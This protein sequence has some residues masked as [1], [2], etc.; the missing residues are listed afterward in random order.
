MIS[1]ILI[2]VFWITLFQSSVFAQTRILFVGNSYTAANNLP[3]LVSDLSA[4]IGDTIVFASNSPGGYTFQLHSSDANTLS[5]IQSQPWDFVVLQEQSQRPAFPP[6]QVAVEVYPYARQLDSLIRLN[7][8]CTETVFYM[9]WGRKYGDVSNCAV[10]PPVCTFSGMQQQLRDAYLQMGDDNTALVA[11]CGMAWQQSWTS[12]SSINLW[13]SDNSHPS[14]EGSYLNA[15]V[16]Y[17]TLFRKSPIGASFTAGLQ[18]SVASY[19]QQ[20]AYSTVFDSLSTWNIGEFD[21]LAAFTA[22]PNG[23]SVQFNYTGNNCNLFQWDFGDGQTATSPAPQHVYAQGGLY[24]VML[25]AGNGCSGDTTVQSISLSAT[26]IS[27][28]EQS[29]CIERKG[30]SFRFNCPVRELNLF[31]ADGRLL[32]QIRFQSGTSTY[33]LPEY[34]EGVLLMVFTLNDGERVAFKTPVI[35]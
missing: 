35:R 5:L 12:D 27:D 24:Q 25:I 33:T 29:D 9:T 3:Q 15:C 19:L 30:E 32:K 13:V 23:L 20:V 14:L 16:F 34:H 1:R 2:I 28:S 17:A 4:S 8:T 7:D 21:P 11:P 26:G 10:W 18:P 6:S 22:Q 31:T